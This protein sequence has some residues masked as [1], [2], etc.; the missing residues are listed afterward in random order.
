MASMR[1][2]ARWYLNEARDGIAWLI[3]SKQGRGW[4]ITSI[5]PNVLDDSGS[6]SIDDEDM[7][8]VW[9][10]LY[11]DPNSVILNSYYDNLGDTECMTLQSLCDAIRRLYDLGHNLLTN[12]IPH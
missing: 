10:A 9:H 4:Y 7:D 8:A 3:V 11:T 5:Y 1:E 6:I 2:Q 12:Y